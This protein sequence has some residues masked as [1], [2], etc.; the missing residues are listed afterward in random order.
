MWYSQPHP[1]AVRRRNVSFDERPGCETRGTGSLSANEPQRE[2]EL[3]N[4]I[5]P[6]FDHLQFSTTEGEGLVTSM[7]TLVARKINLEWPFLVVFVQ[8]LES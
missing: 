6:V 7:S 1:Q 3:A 8:G 5:F 4:I 2:C